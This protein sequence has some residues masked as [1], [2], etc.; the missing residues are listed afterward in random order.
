MT[1]RRKA[2]PCQACAL[3]LTFRGAKPLGGRPDHSTDEDEEAHH[4]HGDH[5]RND[6]KH[7]LFPRHDSLCSQPQSH[8]A[9][10]FRA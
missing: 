1:S 3:V 2:M 8:S 4:D 5:D 6:D 7:Y 9:I 10:S